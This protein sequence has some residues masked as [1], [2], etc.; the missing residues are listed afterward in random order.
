MKTGMIKIS[1]LY[2]NGDG[3]TFDMDYYTGK[4]LPMVGGLL[5]DSLKG[6]ALEKGLGA[7]GDAPAPFLVMSHLY[8]DSV[9]AFEASFG[10]NADAIMADIPNYTNTQPII[11]I[12]VVM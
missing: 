3:H 6:S 2:P 10:P 7:P 12:S 9:Q 4:H 5:G 1:V 11:Q 8:Y